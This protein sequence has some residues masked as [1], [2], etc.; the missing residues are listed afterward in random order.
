MKVPN[1]GIK[2]SDFRLKS[3]NWHLWKIVSVT[4][5]IYGSWIEYTHAR[6]RQ[7]TCVRLFIASLPSLINL[8]PVILLR[9]PVRGCSHCVASSWWL[10]WKEITIK[11]K[12]YQCCGHS[13]LPVIDFHEKSVLQ[14]VVKFQPFVKNYTLLHWKAKLLHTFKIA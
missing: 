12:I 2:T 9:F 3:K 11:S 14:F 8:P 10:K 4:A 1:L 7:Q 13:S 6:M 5:L